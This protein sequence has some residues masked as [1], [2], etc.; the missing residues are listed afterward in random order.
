MK[1]PV[2]LV[3]VA[4]T[5][6]LAILGAESHAQAEPGDDLTVNAL[7]FG[8]GEHPFLKFGH[9]AI[10]IQP[11][12]APGWV[13]NFGTFDFTDPDLIPKFLRGR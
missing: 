5:A 8:P 7:T 4:T 10:L 1:R 11:R 3:S 2:M 9:N 13:F 12:D 6:L